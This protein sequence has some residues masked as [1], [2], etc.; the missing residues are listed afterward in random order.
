MSIPNIISIARLLATP[1]TLYLILQ[2][3]FKP[4]FI[5]F[6]AAGVSDAVDGYIAKRW[7]QTTRLGAFLDPLADKVL[8]VGV[9]VALG[10][11]GQL[12]TWIVILVVFRDVLI[13]GGVLLLLLVL[14]TSARV[15]PHFVSKANTALQLA[16]AA[17]VLADLAVSI[18]FGAI[19]TVLIYVVSLTTLLSGAVYLVDWVSH[20]SSEERRR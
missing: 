7:N 9:Y 6:V 17:T 4:A 3:A 16:L 14:G 8:L 19:T 5:L 13:V 1:I 12:P 11:V 18:D 20:V 2:S 10:V 15:R